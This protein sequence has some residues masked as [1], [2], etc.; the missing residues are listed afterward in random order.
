ME[1]EPRHLWLLGLSG[2]GKSTVG[3][4]LARAL[5]MPWV[6]TDAEI[7]RESGKP[8]PEIFQEEGEEGFRQ[9]ESRILEKI[10]AG[11]ASVVSCGGGVVIRKTN[12]HRMTSTGLRIYLQ[13]DPAILARRLRTS[14]DRPLLAGDEREAT[15][16]KLLAERSPWYEESELSVDV[17]HLKP[18][19]VV[20][21]IQKKLPAPWSR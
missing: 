3:P 13:A 15:L 9:R 20:S 19:E 14:Q 1:K 6:D 10:A 16:Q 11:P 18:E 2:S 5:A 21:A 4:R 8:I 12:R 7:A 17:T